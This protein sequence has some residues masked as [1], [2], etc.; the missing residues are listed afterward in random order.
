MSLVGGA[1][2]VWLASVIAAA[3]LASDPM[4]R[5]GIEVIGLA[6][7]LLGVVLLRRTATAEER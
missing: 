4:R 2:A 1:L 7:A 5:I 3:T 6:A